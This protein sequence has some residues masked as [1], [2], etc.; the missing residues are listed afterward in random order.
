[1]HFERISLLAAVGAI[2]VGA[3]LLVYQHWPSAEGAVILRPH[4]EATLVPA[5]I[6][7]YT[8]KVAPVPARPRTVMVE[9]KA[10]KYDRLV[11]SGRPIDL[12]RAYGLAFDCEI[13][14]RLPMV[15]PRIKVD[16][17]AC[18]DL[19]PGQRASRIEHLRA[20]APHGVHGAWMYLT[21]YEGPAGLFQTLP[22]SPE[23][24]ELIAS[25]RAAGMRT[26]DPFV[27]VQASEI[28]RGN[29]DAE[30]ALRYWVAFLGA[31]ARDRA[32]SFDPASDPH[33]AQLARELALT[34]DAASKAISDG[35]QIVAAA[36]PKPPKE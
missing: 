22:D 3:A 18:G 17:A 11:R 10:D 23:T 16:T 30:A 29:G 20:A 27:M 1:M 31:K 28:A 9:S 36:I 35:Q 14:L 34:P 7:A 6:N 24:T 32:Q 4:T 8:P 13:A 33:V 21:V 25:A 19:T 15:D 12:Y 2:G 5:I 26:A